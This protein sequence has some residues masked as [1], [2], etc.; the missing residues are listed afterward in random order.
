[1]PV[2]L[3]HQYFDQL[4]GLAM[5]VLALISLKEIQ[6]ADLQNPSEFQNVVRYPQQ[7]LH[8][9]QK[10]IY[11]ALRKVDRY[12]KLPTQILNAAK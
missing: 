5:N 10:Q 1:M 4:N 7:Y 2:H 3:L 11:E 8:L 9:F 12:L 6:R